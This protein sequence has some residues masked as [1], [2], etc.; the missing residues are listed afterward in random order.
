M[1]RLTLFAALLVL[2]LAIVGCSQNTDT[3]EA[4]DESGDPWQTITGP[5]AKAIMDEGGDY[6]I[7]DVRTMDEFNEKHIEG[8]VLYPVTSIG[9]DASDYI[10]SLDTTVLVYCRSGNRSATAS[11]IL[12]DLGYT[13]V[14]DF[15]GIID[16]TFG[17]VSEE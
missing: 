10:P 3:T 13:N 14:Y 15:G 5:E 12:A 7:L 4:M 16:W 11:A 17:T 8:A 9:E 1:K 6:I 2:L